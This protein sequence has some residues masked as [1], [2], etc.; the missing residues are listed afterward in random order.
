MHRWAV[1]TNTVG[2]SCLF[3]EFGQLQFRHCTIWRHQVCR[4]G[5]HVC[6]TSLW[7]L[8][9]THISRINLRSSL[10]GT[11]WT[12]STGSSMISLSKI[13]LVSKHYF[14]WITTVIL[15]GTGNCDILAQ[16]HSSA[17]K[18]TAGLAESNGSLPPGG[19]LS[20]LWADC[21]YT[22][23]SSMPNAR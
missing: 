5:R 16:T 12:F 23:I 1:Q 22:G 14:V 17:G 13:S 19:W 6:W 15:L 2:Q 11:I 21:L 9:T 10:T 3:G 18:V 7:K 8:L 4:E 20:H